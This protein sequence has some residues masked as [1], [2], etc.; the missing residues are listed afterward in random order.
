MSEG[1]PKE[2]SALTTMR[3]GGKPKQIITCSNTQQLYDKTLELWE[4]EEKF[5]V[6]AGGSNIV[7]ADDVSDLNVLWLPI[8]ESKLCPSMRITFWFRFKL[9]TLG[10][11]SWSGQ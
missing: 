8:A 5:Q 3:V 10:T 11:S 9:D 1:Y 7:F 4:T 2:L 6:L